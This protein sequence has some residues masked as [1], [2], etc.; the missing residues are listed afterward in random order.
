MPALIP[1][2]DK[3]VQAEFLKILKKQKLDF[4]LSSKV[5]GVEKNASGKMNIT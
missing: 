4:A 2:A 5:V 3:E 1:M